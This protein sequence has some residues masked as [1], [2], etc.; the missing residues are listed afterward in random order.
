MKYG[1]RGE[2]GEGG[3]VKIRAEG[4]ITAKHKTYT[5]NIHKTRRQAGGFGHSVNFQ[6]RCA[7]ELLKKVVSRTLKKKHKL[8]K[9]KTKHEFDVH[10]DYL[11]LLRQSFIFPCFQATSVSHG[12]TCILDNLECFCSIAMFHCRR[13]Y[14]VPGM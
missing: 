3:V 13:L 14:Q 2:G 6:L 8:T 12:E 5:S 9:Q 1:G 7:P 4:K 10:N 11:L